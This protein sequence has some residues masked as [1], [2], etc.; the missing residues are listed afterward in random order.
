[1]RVKIN[2]ALRVCVVE[3]VPL[4]PLFRSFSREGGIAFFLVIF[5]TLNIHEI[6]PP[7]K[8][9]KRKKSFFGC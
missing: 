9:G 7:L 3:K 8:E 1:V 2:K 4:V 6:Q 5:E